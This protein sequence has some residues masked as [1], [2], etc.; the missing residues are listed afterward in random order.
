MR[1][2]LKQ[3]KNLHTGG[4]VFE[5]IIEPNEAAIRITALRQ[6]FKYHGL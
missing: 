4:Q 6:A 5:K 3:R 1:I 2:G